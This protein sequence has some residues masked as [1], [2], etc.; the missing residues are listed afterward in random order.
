MISLYQDNDNPTP[1]RRKR[2]TSF[3]DGAETSEDVSSESGVISKYKQPEKEQPPSVFER[4]QNGL[5]QLP[6]YVDPIINY[7]KLS[8]LI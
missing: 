7:S 3:L 6:F 8:T 1:I 4:L 2:I 5:K